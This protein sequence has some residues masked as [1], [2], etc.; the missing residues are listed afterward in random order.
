MGLTFEWGLYS[1]GTYIFSNHFHVKYANSFLIQNQSKY[2]REKLDYRPTRRHSRLTNH[3]LVSNLSPLN[4]DL[5]LSVIHI[6]LRVGL[7][8]EWD[9]YQNRRVSGGSYIRSGAYIREPLYSKIY[10]IILSSRI[11]QNRWDKL[12]LLKG[13]R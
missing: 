6:F 10:G 3:Q 4:N 7:I 8:F 13:P 9:L 11:Q 1:S 5:F 2:P 12:Y